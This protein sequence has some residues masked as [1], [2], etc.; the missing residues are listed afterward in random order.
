MPILRSGPTSRGYR[1]PT[2]IAAPLDDADTALRRELYFFTLYR[3]LE[4]AM[5]VLVLFGPVADLIGPP[6]H[7]LLARVVAVSY[8]VF[9][10]ALF[11]LGRRGE[12]RTQALAGVAVDLVAGILAIHAIPAAGA[13]IALMLMFNVGAAALLLP[14]RFGLSVSVAAALALVGEHVWS[15]VVDDSGRLLAEPIM[16]AIG[17]LAI[18]TLTSVLGRQMRSSYELA[19]RRGAETAHLVEVNELIIRRLRTGVLLVDGDNRVRLANEAATLLLGDAG[20]GHR[21]LGVAIPELA[22]RLAAWRQDGKADESPLQIAPDQP[23]VV[24]RFTRLLA[25]SEQTLIFLDDTSLVSRR[26]E[27]MTLATLGRFSASLA[28]EIR[29]P[30]AAINYAVQLLEES[31]DIPTADRRLLEI[32]RQQGAR[33][34][35][36]VENV[37][38]LARRETAKP[39]YVE[40]VALARHFVDDYRAGHPLENDSLRSTASK[41]QIATLIDPRQL[42]QI[43]TVLVH[44]ALTYGR[45]PGEPAQ[46]TLNVHVDEHQQPVIDVIDRGPGIPERVAQ[47]LFRPFFTT[48]GHGT[49][50]GL[51]IAREL[52]R[53]NQATLDFIPL[54]GGGSCFRVRMTATAARPEREDERR[55]VAARSRR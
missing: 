55:P 19:E 31:D 9:A 53:A 40:L 37:L 14:A 34:N 20:D 48:S 16:F 42:H 8:F 18:A 35:G 51:Y 3:L 17:F 22:R 26:A 30:L 52:C 4:A 28:H 5:L 13:G 23:E 39:E 50:L 1:L 49:G 43:L 33:M 45:L 12:L 47:Q 32:V 21:D 2:T 46:V 41:P 44:N 11:A 10:A 38:G 7:D 29:N 36:I 27:S 25:G 54:P 24:P 15:M 6:R